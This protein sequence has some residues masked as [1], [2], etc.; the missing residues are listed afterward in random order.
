MTMLARW[1]ALPLNQK[2]AACALS[3]GFL[4]LFASPY[5]STVVAVDVKDLA[6]L[7]EQEKDHVGVSD[8][9]AWIVQGRTDYRLIDLRGEREFAEYHIPTAEN[10]V[11]SSL[12]DAGLSPTEKIVLYSDGG[13]HAYQAWML[14]RAKGYR[15]LYTL[16][17][18]LDQWK[19]EVLFPTLA[20]HATA[21]ERARF[22]RTA[23]VSRFFGGTPRTGGAG[24]T[25]AMKAP[26]LPKV[27][28]P[29]TPTG[30]APARSRKK[31]EGC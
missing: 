18:G 11:L 14:M 20:E 15:N 28:A 19:D 22:E 21:L 24:G 12:P 1:S 17:G 25:V 16:K 29:G 6:S 4:S 2:L 31:K 7:I 3:L 26:E 8:L 13:I 23:S 30:S 9:T 27:E 5:Q 10:L